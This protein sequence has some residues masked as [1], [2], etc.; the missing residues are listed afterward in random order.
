MRRRHRE[1]ARARERHADA[2]D[3][4]DATLYLRAIRPTCMGTRTAITNPNGNR[5]QSYRFEMTDDDHSR[6]AGALRA[7]AGLVVVS[8]YDC[9]LYSEL[10]QG[11][12][13]VQKSTHAD[14][15]RARIEVLWLSPRTA[16]ALYHSQPL[17]RE[18]R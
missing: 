1:S 13:R 9:P 4:V 6:L 12:H 5:R 7:A 3:R 11:W 8:G 15:A 14:G 17:L 10:Y 2:F 18:A 16:D